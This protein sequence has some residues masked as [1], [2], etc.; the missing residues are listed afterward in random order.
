[1]QKPAS[2]DYLLSGILWCK[3]HQAFY[4]GHST[5]GR[6]YYI[7][8]RRK[9]KGRSVADCPLVKKDAIEKF[10]LDNLKEYIFTP[11]RVREGLGILLEESRGNIAEGTTE[12]EQLNQSLEKTETEL[13]NLYDA[14]KKGVSPEALGRPIE[15]ARARKVQLQSQLR[16]LKDSSPKEQFAALGIVEVTDGVIDGI[17]TEMHR[18]LESSSAQEL[19][20]LLGSILDKIEISGRELTIWYTIAPSQKIGDYWRPR[21]VAISGQLFSYTLAMDVALFARS[22]SRS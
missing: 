12:R 21:G 4:A 1:M 13:Q 6:T 17:V 3:K 14:I 8:G 15:E 18:L 22:S 19:K 5:E 16:E 20:L 2:R 9:K 7:C 10:V 11:E